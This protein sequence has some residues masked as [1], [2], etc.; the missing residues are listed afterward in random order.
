M[1]L[2]D[3]PHVW[4]STSLGSWPH[5]ASYSHH[6]PTTDYLIP[7]PTTR[8]SAK[9]SSSLFSSVAAS[10]FSKPRH[11]ASPGLRMCNPHQVTQVA[12]GTEAHCHS[13]PS[14]VGPQP[15]PV[16]R[17]LVRAH[18]AIRSSSC[19]YQPFRPVTPN[20]PAIQA[21]QFQPQWVM[22]I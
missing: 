11:P 18:H 14:T 21:T 12:F 17:E 4:T 20:G 8:T 15:E 16:W 19:V 6:Y 9:P 1:I 3:G 7:L 13:I 22:L 10:V 2:A 5:P